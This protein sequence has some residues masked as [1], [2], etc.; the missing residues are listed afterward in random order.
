MVATYVRNIKNIQE[1][2]GS[3]AYY[4]DPSPANYSVPVLTSL[5]RD[6]SFHDVR[7]LPVLVLDNADNFW[8]AYQAQ[9]DTPGSLVVRVPAERL[10][11]NTLV[12]DL[13]NFI[14]KHWLNDIEK[15]ILLDAADVSGVQVNAYA[16]ALE[17]V[18]GRLTR[19]KIPNASFAFGSASYPQ[20]LQTTEW[21][22]K[23]V[24]RKDLALWK[25]LQAEFPELLYADY[26]TSPASTEGDFSNVTPT[27]KARYT[28][29]NELMVLRSNYLKRGPLGPRYERISTMIVNHA[30]YKG[31][32]F[33]WGDGHIYNCH[34][35]PEADYTRGGSTEWVTVNTSHHI[36]H[37]V[38]MLAAY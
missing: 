36:E 28:L 14:G 23:L 16:M 21:V 10:F 9:F 19:A 4:L 7:P 26:A 33:S 31:H 11:L 25:H 35:L 29:N 2:S 6:L 17:A 18:L 24:E 32:G 13:K 20:A 27:P 3:I 5:L 12:Q 34:F 15:I 8:F 22:I 30:Q 37:V 1:T 38:E